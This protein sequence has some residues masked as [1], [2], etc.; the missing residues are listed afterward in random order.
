[1]LD[2]VFYQGLPKGR[3]PILPDIIVA[4]LPH[5]LSEMVAKTALKR[6]QPGA[7]KLAQC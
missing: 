5:A 3:L 1:M 6:L 4:L 2:P 7:V